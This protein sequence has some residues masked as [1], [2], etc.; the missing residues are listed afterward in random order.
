MEKLSVPQGLF[1]ISRSPV[2]KK[3]TLRAW[4][5][6]DEF[7]LNEVAGNH[8]ISAESRILILNDTFGA[9]SVALSASNPV[10]VSDSFL[11]HKATLQN[12]EYNQIESD[13][14][15]LTFLNTELKSHY[16]T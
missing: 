9:L 16:F 12:I 10:M 5:A 8:L 2:R 3:E 1:E 13:R 14:I 6:A 11:S 15:V 4:D 7:L